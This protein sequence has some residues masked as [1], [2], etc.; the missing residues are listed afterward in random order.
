MAAESTP[1]SYQHREL[2][3]NHYA[4]TGAVE[5]F[6]TRPAANRAAELALEGEV[7]VEQWYENQDPMGG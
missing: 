3:G 7:I 1:N 6:C 2:G 5:E 4:Q